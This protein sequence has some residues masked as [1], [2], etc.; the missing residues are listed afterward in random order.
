LG[1]SLPATN[2]LYIPEVRFVKE[3]DCLIFH[4]SR[5]VLYAVQVTESQVNEHSAVTFKTDHLPAAWA[6]ITLKVLWIAKP[7]K[8]TLRD[9]AALY[10]G[11]LLCDI[12]EFATVEP[13]LT[14]LVTPP[15][16]DQ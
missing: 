2:M 15:V 9:R 11:Q 10:E 13:E 6:S 16:A 14:V 8:T 12:T 3:I 7:F 5:S 1:T 4:R